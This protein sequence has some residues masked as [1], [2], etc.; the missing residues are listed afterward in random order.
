MSEMVSQY[1]TNCPEM[2][3]QARQTAGSQEHSIVRPIYRGV[4]RRFEE[5]W[6]LLRRKDIETFPICGIAKP[7]IIANE[8]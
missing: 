8:G 2:D 3:L 6:L 5:L 7:I 1:Q 4:I